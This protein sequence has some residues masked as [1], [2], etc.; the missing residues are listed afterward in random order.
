MGMKGN[1]STFP[2]VK[3]LRLSCA[4]WDIEV[5]VV[6]KP[7]EADPQQIADFWSKVKDNSEWSLHPEVYEKVIQHPILQG[8]E[9]KYGHL[10]KHTTT[11]VQEAFYS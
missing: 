7:R 4:Q 1:A 2:V 5:E 9:T 10:Y 3:E 8:R 6:W 11:K